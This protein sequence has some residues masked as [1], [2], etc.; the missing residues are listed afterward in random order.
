METIQTNEEMLEKIRAD[1]PN[2]VIHE[3]ISFKLGS[4]GYYDVV[5]DMEGQFLNTKVSHVRQTLP[6]PLN[7]FNSLATLYGFTS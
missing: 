6:Y 2:Q 7:R 5:V 4:L 3:V 1:R